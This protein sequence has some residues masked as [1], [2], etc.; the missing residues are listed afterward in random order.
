[1][2]DVW[3]M[4]YCMM[5]G[6]GALYCTSCFFGGRVDCTV[7][8]YS[9]NIVLSWH[10]TYCFQCKMRTH[11]PTS[12]C[13]Q[14]DNV[15]YYQHPWAMDEWVASRKILPPQIKMFEISSAINP[16]G[17]PF[18]TINLRRR[19]PKPTWRWRWRWRWENDD[20]ENT[21]PRGSPVNGVNVRVFLAW[22]GYI[23][24]LPTVL[25]WDTYIPR[26]HY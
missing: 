18:E 11:L 25:Y 3:C 6:V 10:D 15:L 23:P 22:V 2:Y 26:Y 8:L 24:D 19:K 12:R 5:Y 4:M 7:V 20:K 14:S 9:W 17:E 21:W 13:R 1:M 16:W